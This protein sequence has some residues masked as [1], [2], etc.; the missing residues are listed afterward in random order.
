MGFDN[1][2]WHSGLFT[3]SHRVTSA[4]SVLEAVIARTKASPARRLTIKHHPCEVSFIDFELILGDN[5]CAVNQR[6]KHCVF[7]AVDSF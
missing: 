7:V 4:G 5:Q 2:N 6:H 3:T 1:R